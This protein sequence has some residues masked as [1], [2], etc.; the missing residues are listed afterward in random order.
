M[1]TSSCGRGSGK[2]LKMG[3]AF[4][5]VLRV[6]YRRAV[7]LQGGAWRGVQP[8]AGGSLGSRWAVGDSRCKPWALEA[9]RWRVWEAASAGGVHLSQVPG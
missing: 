7:V 6:P 5:S 9:L 4:P 8:S 3:L 1:G 2:E